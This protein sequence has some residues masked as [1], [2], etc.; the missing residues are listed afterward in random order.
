MQPPCDRVNKEG[1]EGPGWDPE[2][3]LWSLCKAT[4]LCAILLPPRGCRRL[5]LDKGRA[6]AFL[7]A[8]LP[9]SAPPRH[10]AR[11]HLR[12]GQSH[13]TASGGPTAPAHLDLTTRPCSDLVSCH[14]AFQLPCLGFPPQPL[15]PWAPAQA[16]RARPLYPLCGPLRSSGR[17]LPAPIPTYQAFH[18]KN[19]C[20]CRSP[21]ASSV[22]P[23]PEAVSSVM[24]W[25]FSGFL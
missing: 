23:G 22:M 2:E 25:C 21:T 6:L 7:L 16:R 24:S 13:G 3:E 1:W 20:F 15:N 4:G 19:A 8:G 11:A 5:S 18:L 12:C 14:P 17:P 9:R 10:R